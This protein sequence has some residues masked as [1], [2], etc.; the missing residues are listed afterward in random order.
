[1]TSYKNKNLAIIQ[2]ADSKKK[3]TFTIYLFP[4]EIPKM[5]PKAVSDGCKNVLY[6]QSR[7]QTGS[8]FRPRS[9]LF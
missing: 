9:R 6:V 7:L 2:Y 3:N 5:S 1:M 8:C 4:I